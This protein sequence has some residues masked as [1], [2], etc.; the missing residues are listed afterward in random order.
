MTKEVK[1]FDTKLKDTPYDLT[2]VFCKTP[3]NH[4]GYILQRE[5]Y[6]ELINRIEEDITI[7]KQSI[8]NYPIGSLTYRKEIHGL[9]WHHNEL[10]TSLRYLHGFK[11]LKKY[12]GSHILDEHII[13]L[14]L[15]GIEEEH[16]ALLH[17]GN[18]VTVTRNTPGRLEFKLHTST[19]PKLFYLDVSYDDVN[20]HEL[21]KEAILNLLAIRKREV[22]I[23]CINDSELVVIY[24]ETNM[25]RYY[26][27]IDY[28]NEHKREGNFSHMVTEISK[29]FFEFIYNEKGGK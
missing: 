27:T 7:Q 2:G 28:K 15:L 20:R 10:K 25:G 19:N 14:V 1:V 6:L 12:I 26:S 17:K 3:S 8:S 23:N 24:Y 29:E 13:D 11:E 4:V 5:N 16:T 9:T 18:Y 21:Y 22:V